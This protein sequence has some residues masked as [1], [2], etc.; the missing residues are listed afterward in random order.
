M[1]AQ[2]HGRLQQHSE[3][4][5]YA[6]QALAIRPSHVDAQLQ[7][8]SA[9][10]ELG[11]IEEARQRIEDILRIAA[12]DSRANLLGARIYTRKGGM[13]RAE[14]LCLTAL[15][16]DPGNSDALQVLTAIFTASNRYP[17]AVVRAREFCARAPRNATGHFV[18][19]TVLEQTRDFEEAEAA[20]R[21]AI[22]LNG[23]FVDACNALGGL[24]VRLD[25]VEDAYRVFQRALALRPRNAA[26]LNN[27]GNSLRV[28]RRSGEA[29]QAFRSAIAL[30]PGNHVFHANLGNVLMED[31]RFDAAEAV[32]HQTLA[33]QPDSI[34]AHVT[35]MFCMNHNPRH[36]RRDIFEAH[37]AWARQ[38]AQPKA[39]APHPND[40]DPERRLRVGY[41]S[42]DFRSHPVSYFIEPV[43]RGHD[44]SRFEVFCYSEVSV[45]DAV[46]QRLQSY[47]CT[48]RRT[49]GCSDIDL[50]RMIQDDCI[51]VLVDLAGHT[52]DS[53]LMAMR[54]SPTPVQV[55]YLG[56]CNTTGFPSVEW[57]ITDRTADP[58]GSQAYYS[59]KLSYLEPCF[60]AYA[61]P[62]DAPPVAPLPAIESGAVTFGSLANTLKL[63][64][65][66]IE[67]WARAV[68]AVPG[69]RLL[70]ARRAIHD[71][72]RDRLIGAFSDHGLD[73]GRIEIVRILPHEGH[74]GVYGRI[75]ISLDTF[76]WSGHTTSCEALY[77]GVPTVT[78]TGDRH[79]SRMVASLLRGVGLPHLVAD[80]PE[81]YITIAR[82][83]AADIPAL[84]R[85]RAG[86]RA[87]FLA[88]P[89]CD[90]EG[91][92]R[93]LE[94]A[95]RDMWR[96][97]CTAHAQVVV[98]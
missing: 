32:L 55:S 86:L 17:D 52:R 60:F 93:K 11:E 42:P 7:L 68:D 51:D 71:D 92:T 65:G 61:P 82:N 36:T 94:A 91:F 9:L 64:P 77:M 76:P 67:L 18:L 23:D 49:T 40:P 10:F 75:D 43:F 27:L 56:Y 2:I 85:L 81:A 54:Y 46:T 84:A 38:H 98:R 19:G 8:A 15:A 72:L 22:R 21:V 78:L 95:Y 62:L 89:V 73:P 96:A 44:R 28:L 16:T 48:W 59:E 97:W 20:Y 74:L 83:L 39:R 50:A 4:A 87:Q 90:A 29:E 5:A 69:S 12:Q 70:I 80:T 6:R 13:E 58:E 37:V 33:L 53:R 79:A 30:D 45:E 3:A 57:W 63:H 35:L 47:E 26:L 1:L 41:V 24:L 25:R 31:A 14:R 34:P 88:S 66:V